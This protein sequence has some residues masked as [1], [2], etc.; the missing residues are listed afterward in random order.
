LVVRSTLHQRDER[1]DAAGQLKHGPHRVDIGEKR[2]LPL[3]VA[4]EELGRVVRLYVIEKFVQRVH[5]S[6]RWRVG[7]SRMPAGLRRPWHKL[8]HLL[9]LL[10]AAMRAWSAKRTRTAT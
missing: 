10:A 8:H 9:N 2:R 4:R 7:E 3:F 1:R 5:G 6:V